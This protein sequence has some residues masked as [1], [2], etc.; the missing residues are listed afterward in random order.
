MWYN[1]YMTLFSTTAAAYI[2]P[3]LVACVSTVVTA[4][5]VTVT[6]KLIRRQIKLYNSIRLVELKSN[7]LHY[8]A[9]ICLL[10]FFEFFC[11]TQ[12]FD[13]AAP[14]LELVEKL[15]G[16]TTWQYDVSLAFAI[17]L[18]TAVIVFLAAVALG[19]CA[20]VDG[21]VFTVFSFL[22]WYHVHDY[23]IDEDKGVV[24]L[25]G[26]KYTFQTLMSTTP[27]LKVAKDDVPKLKFIL[28]KNKNKF[29]GFASE[30]L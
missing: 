18:L 19:K 16:M 4:L 25:S 8:W 11:F 29:S 30:T 2:I 17:I 22:D 14:E 7:K 26:N 12:L 13:P 21:G 20:V 27:P 15:F 6:V 5:L 10:L 23:L 9:I 24:V 3:V 1:A 28:N